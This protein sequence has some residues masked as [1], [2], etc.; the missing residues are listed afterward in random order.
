MVVEGAFRFSRHPGNLAP[1]GFMLLF[2]RMTV[3]T[4]TLAALTVVYTVLG[5][6][7]EEYR[8]KSRYPSA[9]GR[10]QREVPFMVPISG[11]SAE[12]R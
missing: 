8:H 11:R 9:Y 5:S 10:Y 2:P 3:N 7:H 12:K 4:A 6:L 1:I